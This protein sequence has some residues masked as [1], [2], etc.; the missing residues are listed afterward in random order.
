MYHT[1]FNK[2]NQSGTPIRVVTASRCDIRDFADTALGRSIQSSAVMFDL[3]LFVQP[4][5]RES[6]ATTYNQVLDL[7]LH[8]P[9]LLVFV[10]DDVLIADFFWDRALRQALERFDIVGLAGTTRRHP[11]QSSWCW[12]DPDMTQVESNQYLSGVVAHGS[13]F[14]PR[15]IGCFGDTGRKCLLL[16]GLFLAADS[17]S[18]H[19]H[20]VRFDPAFDFHFY[21]LDFCRQA[22]A[23]GLSMGTMAITVLHDSK[24]VYDHS[25]R[26]QYKRYLSKWHN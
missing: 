12:I 18:L 10:H 13:G 24:N 8:D 5:N 1:K 7:S 6:L 16:D 25:W 17:R 22:E 26:Q 20:N 2:F 9:A 4:D 3:E 21:D 15:N 11:N 23:S 14:P 19:Q